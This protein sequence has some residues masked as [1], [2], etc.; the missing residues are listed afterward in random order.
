MTVR[1]MFKFGGGRGCAV[2]LSGCLFSVDPIISA[3]GAIFDSRLLRKWEDVSRSG[4]IV[5]AREAGNTYAIEYGSDAKVGRFEAQLGQLGEPVAPATVPCFKASEWREADQLFHRDP[6]WVGGDGASSVDL[7]HG[8]I[9]WLFGDSWIDPSGQGTRQGA[10]LVSNSVAIQTGTDPVAASIRFYWGRA[11]DGS[12]AAFVPDDGEERHWFG[13]GVRVGDRLVLFLNQVR[14]AP[15]GLG[16][17]SVG[18]VAWMVENPDAEPSSM[19]P[20]SA[21]NTD[22]SA[23]R[24]RGICRRIALGRACLRIRSRGPGQIA[25]DLCRTMDGARSP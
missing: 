2:A 5:V 16:F 8:R 24:P 6:H 7:G 19:A 15:T 21:C 3:S 12:P 10:S 13:N 4:R 1:A 20:P 23:G 18:W 14:S 11:A 17:K 25:P 9:L 22:E